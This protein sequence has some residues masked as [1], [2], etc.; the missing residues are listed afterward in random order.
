MLPKGDPD[1]GGKI[2]AIDT[3]SQSRLNT[4]ERS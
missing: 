3:V 2:L 1:P 4:I